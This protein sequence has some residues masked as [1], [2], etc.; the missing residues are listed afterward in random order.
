MEV[1]ATRIGDETLRRVEDEKT[2][3]EVS[4]WMD[5]SGLPEKARPQF[6]I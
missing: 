6:G 5:Q 2:A 1:R 3:K 4:N